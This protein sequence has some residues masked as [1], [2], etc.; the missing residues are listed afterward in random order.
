MKKNDRKIYQEKGNKLLDAI[1]SG[2]LMR[3]KTLVESGADVNFS[4]NETR[5]T[6]LHEAASQGQI[7]IAKFFL[8]HG[9]N[10]NGKNKSGYTILHGAIDPKERVEKDGNIKM[11]KFLLDHGAKRARNVWGL[12]EFFIAAENNQNP[13][14][15]KMFSDGGSHLNEKYKWDYTP[16]MAAVRCNKSPEV[17][18]YLIKEGAD[19]N[20]V[21]WE[22]T[23]VLMHAACN[24]E[25][26]P[27]NLRILL[28]H[29]ANLNAVNKRG[30][31]AI[32]CAKEQFN[33]KIKEFILEWEAKHE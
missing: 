10:I 8:D 12:D 31:K 9:A 19:I 17:I 24:Y 22:D 29:G 26:D 27:T 13:E 21:D 15:L 20:A 25:D 2:S 14:V 30:M 33:G 11:V 7:E 1:E 23:S 18:Q 3:I 6:P 16:L 4:D 5:Y 28:E 32:D